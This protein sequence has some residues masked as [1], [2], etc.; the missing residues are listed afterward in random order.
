MF[1]SYAVIPAV[2]PSYDGLGLDEGSRIVS[3]NM[4]YREGMASATA[5]SELRHVDV[6]LS[7]W[8]GT[9]LITEL[10]AAD[11]VLVCYQRISRKRRG[12]W[13]D[14]QYASVTLAASAD[15][16]QAIENGSRIGSQSLQ[17]KPL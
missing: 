3:V 10:R 14:E 16:A 1:G 7:Y 5:T 6:L 9:E 2:C 8:R 15:K 17:L 4:E 13:F 11:V 12:S